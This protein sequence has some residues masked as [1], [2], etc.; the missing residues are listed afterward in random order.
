MKLVRKKKHTHTD[1]EQ[2]LDVYLTQTHTRVVTSSQ[3]T[4][5]LPLISMQIKA[6]SMAAELRWVITRSCK[7]F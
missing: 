3:A 6:R 1:H 4:V 2:A 7:G 5:T